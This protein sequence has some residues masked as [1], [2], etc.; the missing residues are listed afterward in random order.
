[1]ADSGVGSCLTRSAMVA[2]STGHLSWPFSSIQKDECGETVANVWYKKR[3]LS[4]LW[5]PQM[6]KRCFRVNVWDCNTQ[7]LRNRYYSANLLEKN[8]FI[9]SEV[10]IVPTASLSPS[11]PTYNAKSQLDSKLQTPRLPSSQGQKRTPPASGSRSTSSPSTHPNNHLTSHRLEINVFTRTWPRSQA[12]T[13]LSITVLSI[14]L[15]SIR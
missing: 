5:M 8:V 6:P 15:Q 3:S 4:S 13:L 1:M 10:L 14:C 11:R 2:S 7:S 9:S 12:S